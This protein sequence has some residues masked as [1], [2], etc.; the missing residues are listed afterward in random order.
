M[1]WGGSL[2]AD[3]EEERDGN[4]GDEWGGRGRRDVGGVVIKAGEENGGGDE[5]RLE[6]DGE[7]EE[8]GGDGGCGNGFGRESDGEEEGG[9]EAGGE[10]VEEKMVT[11]SVARKMI[12][13]SSERADVWGACFGKR[14]GCWRCSRRRL[15]R[16]GRYVANGCCSCLIGRRERLG[17]V[18]AAAHHLL[19]SASKTPLRTSAIR[20]K[21]RPASGSSVRKT[22]QKEEMIIESHSQT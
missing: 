11:G 20:V 2:V 5:G 13:R 14:D 9:V 15:K 3:D 16:R 6:D 19:V 12:G 10:E 4:G 8:D 21:C 18:P 7:L 17:K 22:S 1:V